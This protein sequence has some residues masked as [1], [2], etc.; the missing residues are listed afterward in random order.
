MIC[1]RSEACPFFSRITKGDELEKMYRGNFCY[2]MFTRCARYVVLKV[3]GKV[4]NDLYPNMHDE[5][6]KL[7]SEYTKEQK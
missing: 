3:C 7:C 6:T 5:A 4:P 1:E 2:G